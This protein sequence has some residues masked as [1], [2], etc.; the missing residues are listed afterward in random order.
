[1]LTLWNG[2]KGGCCSEKPSQA[3][4]GSGLS[5]AAPHRS[6]CAPGT[7]ESGTDG[8][9]GLFPKLQET[10]SILTLEADSGEWGGGGEEAHRFGCIRCPPT[11]SPRKHPFSPSPVLSAGPRRSGRLSG[12]SLREP[13]GRLAPR[14]TSAGGGGGVGGV[15]RNLGSRRQPLS[16]SPSQQRSGSGQGA[17]A[18]GG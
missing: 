12:L 5:E 18:A 6:S 4:Q 7:G 3:L 15:S 11:S 2:N 8:E 1:M 13:L 14:E 16:P 10:V 9:L 17:A